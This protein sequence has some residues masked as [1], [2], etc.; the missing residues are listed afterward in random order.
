MWEVIEAVATEF[1]Y[2]R[3]GEVPGKPKERGRVVWS[4]DFPKASGLEGEASAKVQDVKVL[5][6]RR[7]KQALN[8]WAGSKFIDDN[9]QTAGLVPGQINQWG[10]TLLQNMQAGE[11]AGS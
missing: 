3:A 7:L 6:F 10:R 2:L 4:A 8:L 1:H 5:R 9:N 11:E